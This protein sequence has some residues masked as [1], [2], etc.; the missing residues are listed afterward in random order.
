VQADTLKGCKL[1]VEQAQERQ[2]DNLDF[3]ITA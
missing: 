3:R 2:W 1:R